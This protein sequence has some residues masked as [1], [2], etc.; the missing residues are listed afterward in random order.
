MGG[1]N[2]DPL[3]PTMTVIPAKAGIHYGRPFALRS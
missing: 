1:R 3:A 2:P